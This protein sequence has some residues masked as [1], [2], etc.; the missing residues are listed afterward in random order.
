MAE[1]ARV[2]AGPVEM[3]P[4]EMQQVPGEPGVG[5]DHIG[6]N[7][8][9]SVPEIVS[10]VSLAREPLGGHAMALSARRRLAYLKQVETHRLLHPRVALDLDIR[11]LPESVVVLSLLLEQP[12]LA[13]LH[14]AVEGAFGPV[15]QLLHVAIL[16]KVVGQELGQVDRLFQVD[17]NGKNH[18]SPIFAAVD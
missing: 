6:Q 15:G 13:D 8:D 9:L 17:V 3:G 4:A 16:S 18:L 10:F 7:V 11:P 12:G 1:F 5:V 2:G 14:G